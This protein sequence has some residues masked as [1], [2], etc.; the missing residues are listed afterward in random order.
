MITKPHTGLNSLIC[1]TMKQELAF[2]L[3]PKFWTAKASFCLY[4]LSGTAKALQIKEA[5]M[6]QVFYRTCI[7]AC[8]ISRS[9]LRIDANKVLMECRR[10][11]A[12]H[13]PSL[14]TFQVLWTYKY[15]RESKRYDHL[16]KL[17]G[18]LSKLTLRDLLALQWM[19]VG[20]NGSQTWEEQ[21]WTTWKCQLYNLD[22]QLNRT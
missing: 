4:F 9:T 1:V 20:Y 10:P 7:V 2:C 5:Q 22:N 13:I 18:R 21:V 11:V 6:R 17:W 15:D 8:N 19:S 12:E 3:N 16:Q 14:E